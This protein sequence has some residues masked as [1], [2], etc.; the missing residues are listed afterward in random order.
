MVAVET[1]IAKP[2]YEGEYRHLIPNDI[3]KFAFNP[4][5]VILCC[6]CTVVLFS[7]KSKTTSDGLEGKIIYDVTFPY[8]QNKLMLEL[9]P[10]EM[11]LQFKGSKMHSKIRS[12][13]DVMTTDLIL[14]EEEKNAIQMLKNMSKRFAVEMNEGQV[15][16]WVKQYP[17]VRIENTSA[18]ETIAGYVCTKSIAH[19]ENDSLPVIEL[20]HTKGIGL[21]HS[22]WW[23]QFSA[24]DGFLLGYDIE[25]YG[26]RMKLRARS[27]SFEPV[28]DAEFLVSKEYSKV[29]M[30]E[31]KSEIDAV[32][33]SFLQ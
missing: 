14:D 28:S 5:N 12:S 13:Y 21:S 7:C 32:M 8:E 18:T 30:D 15:K 31:M 17:L 16:E 9:Y 20:Y 26:K 10:K 25:Q 24:V 11:V 33:K 4:L 6:L 23:N 27:V 1:F 29:K 22:N 3:L 2:A 19:F